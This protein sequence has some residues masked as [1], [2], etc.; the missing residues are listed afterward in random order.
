M[1]GVDLERSSPCAGKGTKLEQLSFLITE[2]QVG[3][4]RSTE[5][6]F[7]LET[8]NCSICLFLDTIYKLVAQVKYMPLSRRTRD[9]FYTSSKLLPSP[10]CNR[11]GSDI[12]LFLL[13]SHIYTFA[14]S[15]SQKLL[16]N[17]LTTTAALLP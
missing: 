5:T 3:H 1:P 6:G 10:N 14:F 13:F 7:P 15:V 9:V 4:L 8:R 12:G 16:N 17:E 11:M 2:R